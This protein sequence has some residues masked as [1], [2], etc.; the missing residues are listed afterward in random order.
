MKQ[1]TYQE[2]KKWPKFDKAAS[3]EYSN[4]AYNA[5]E[6]DNDDDFLDESKEHCA[7][8]AMEMRIRGFLD[9][10]GI[11]LVQGADIFDVACTIR[12]QKH[13]LFKARSFIMESTNSALLRKRNGLNKNVLKQSLFI[14]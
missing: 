6:I 11:R 14:R 3:A 5:L 1:S 10:E 8:R 7:I 4:M 9:E 13:S 12:T 2:E